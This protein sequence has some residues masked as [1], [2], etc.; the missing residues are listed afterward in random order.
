[1]VGGL[2]GAGMC[3]RG[4]AGAC[5][6]RVGGG[7]VAGETATAAD[8]THPTGMHSCCSK[9]LHLKLLSKECIHYLLSELILQWKNPPPRHNQRTYVHM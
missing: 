5:M 3:G 7:C 9:N 8:G 2:H 1:M 4:A 6:P